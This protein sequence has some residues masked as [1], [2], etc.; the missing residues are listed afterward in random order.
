MKALQRYLF[1]SLFI[2][3]ASCS[4][5]VDLSR[6]GDSKTPEERRLL[7]T[8]VDRTIER[9]LSANA[10]DGYRSRGEYGNSG[11]SKRVA[12]NLADRHHI[13]FIAQWP[14]TT[15]GVSCVVYEVPESLPLQQMITELEHDQDVASVQLMQQFRV[16]SDNPDL[17]KPYSDPYLKLQTGFQSLGIAELHKIATGHGVKIALIDTGVD[18]DHPDLQGQIQ[19]SED[20]APEPPTVGFADVHGTAVAGI[21]SARPDNGVGIAGIAPDA[22]ILA[23]RACWPDK[24]GSLAARCNS[25]T[26]ALALNM[27]IRLESQIVN[28]SLSGPDD[29]L[30]R[31][32]IE[33]ALNQGII[34][35]AAVPG[36]DQSG[37]FPANIPG[38]IAVGHGSESKQSQIVAPD[39]DIL[40]TIPQQ[41]YDFVTGSSFA[42]PHVV[43]IAALLLQINPKFKG[44]DIKQLFETHTNL[45]TTNLLELAKNQPATTAR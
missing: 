36:K 5:T 32:L 28:L 25:F 8:F 42:T 38:V 43:G 31:L 6:L 11:W 15:L 44:A 9:D 40:T 45:A 39:K 2:G 24:P 18:L 14:V 22:E 27:A 4:N 35:I 20:F 19:Y 23:L 21:L 26:L 33:K 16:L 1:I 12:I 41:R 13:Q 34:I 3:L 29:P 10:Q 17:S 7:V 30:L 37:G